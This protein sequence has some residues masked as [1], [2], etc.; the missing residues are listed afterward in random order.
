MTTPPP[1]GLGRR[2]SVDS[3]DHQFLMR[4]VAPAV[5][6]LPPRMIY[7]RGP[8]LDQGKTGTC[9][10]H[11]WRDWLTGAPVA[12]RTG[13]SPFAIYDAATQVDEWTDN[14]HDTDRQ[15]GTS[16][17][18]GAQVLSSL[19]HISTYLWAFN[20]EDVRQW[21]LGGRGGV[22]LGIQWLE[23]FFT[24]DSEGII[25]ITTNQVA[26]GHALFAFGF[27]DHEGMIYLQNS[28]GKDYGGWLVNKRPSYAGCV[29]LPLEDFD[30]LLR[31]DG[32]CAT[33]IQQ[34][35]HPNYRRLVRY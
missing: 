34:R 5:T 11:A 22:V 24:P 32:E 30:R 15:M 12:I 23:S 8:L 19:G 2:I 31:E 25:R 33:A 20:A 21:M 14:D 3:R 9:V 7:R 28:W 1:G 6:P 29:R 18:A 10:G 27:D 13:P 4:A 16:V 26:G 17:R 35:V